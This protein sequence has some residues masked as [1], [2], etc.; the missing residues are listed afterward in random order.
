MNI[1]IYIFTYIYF[2]CFSTDDLGLSEDTSTATY[3]TWI[4]RTTADD[5]SLFTI[6]T[7]LNGNEFTL[8]YK[9]A[10]LE[11]HIGGESVLTDVTFPEDEWAHL[12]VSY[13]SISGDI[14]IYLDSVFV[15]THT[16][17]ADLPIRSSNT[18]VCNTQEVDLNSDDGSYTFDADQ[19]FVGYQAQFYFF[20]RVLNE[21]EVSLMF[22]GSVVDDYLFSYEE[23]VAPETSSAETEAFP[24][25]N[26]YETQNGDF[27]LVSSMSMSLYINIFDISTLVSVAN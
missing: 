21:A 9:N 6:A 8:Y 20:N 5:M 2:F 18:I 19:S 23:W 11:V 17:T 16:Q 27:P 12:C 7:D 22:T 10:G 25:A 26:T 24:L 14:E 13:S 3:C 1:C 4:R 15:Y